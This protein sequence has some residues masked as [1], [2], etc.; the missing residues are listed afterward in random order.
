MSSGAGAVGGVDVVAGAVCVAV[1]MVLYCT[2]WL[3]FCK[4]GLV[5][6]WRRRLF[7]RRR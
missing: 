7:G 5:I 4:K 3:A 1:V 2:R 6:W